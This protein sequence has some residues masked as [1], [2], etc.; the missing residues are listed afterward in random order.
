MRKIGP[1]LTSVAYLPLFFSL[2]SPST[3]LYVLVVSPSSSSV[4]DAATAWLDE[5]CVDLCPGSELVNVGACK[6]NQTPPGQPL[7]DTSCCSILLLRCSHSTLQGKNEKPNKASESIFWQYSPVGSGM[8][9]EVP[10]VDEDTDT[11]SWWL[12]YPVNQEHTSP[13]TFPKR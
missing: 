10:S 7:T 4:W 12:F 13:G 11:R 1:E 9:A 6:L 3:W 5:Q 8:P 2:Q